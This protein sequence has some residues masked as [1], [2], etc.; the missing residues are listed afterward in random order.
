MGDLVNKVFLKK[1]LD[2]QQWKESSLLGFYDVNAGLF[3]QLLRDTAE[4]TM[5][6]TNIGVKCFSKSL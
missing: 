5:P 6:N 3:H 1:V 4:G 2:L